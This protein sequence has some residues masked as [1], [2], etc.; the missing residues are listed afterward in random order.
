[1]K[2]KKAKTTCIRCDKKGTYRYGKGLCQILSLNLWVGVY[3][4]DPHMQEVEEEYVKFR[5]QDQ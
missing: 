5:N 4:C 1:M 2:K 3:L